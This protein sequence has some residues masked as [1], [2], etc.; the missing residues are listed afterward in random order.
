M[1]VDGHDCFSYAFRCSKIIFT[2]DELMA[3]RI[4]DVGMVDRSDQSNRT[5]FSDEG[6]LNK[7]ELINSKIKI[8]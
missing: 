2:F 4:V 1:S 5:R 8:F 6:D 3:H 7:I